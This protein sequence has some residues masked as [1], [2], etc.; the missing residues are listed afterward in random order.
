MF[1]EPVAG[2]TNTPPFIAEDIASRLK[3]HNS[4]LFWVDTSAIC[5]S[6][7]VESFNTTATNP[8]NIEG[9]ETSLAP[10]TTGEP[11]NQDSTSS[12]LAFAVEQFRGRVIPI[13]SLLYTCS[14][15]PLACT[16]GPLISG[17][18]LAQSTVDSSGSV[19][20][21]DC[22]SV[23]EVPKQW[24]NDLGPVLWR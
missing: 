23:K 13:S 10:T 12:T 7:L 17:Q 22:S 14:L 3:T 8:E 6:R 20:S 1:A 18:F 16:V 21:T 15:L 11:S 2:N 9:T 19:G 4:A 24:N 5:P